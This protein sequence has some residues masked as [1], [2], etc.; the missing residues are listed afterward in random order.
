MDEQERELRKQER[1]WML[2]GALL[3]ILLFLAIGLIA[4]GILAAMGQ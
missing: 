1:R 4:L 3:T 2:E